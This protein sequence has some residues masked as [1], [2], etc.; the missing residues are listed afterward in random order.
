MK[1]VS[2]SESKAKCLG[3]LGQVRKTHTPVPVTRLGKPVAKVVPA[4]PGH[5]TGR[6]LGCMAGT[7]EI[8]GD[9]VVPTGGWG[10]CVPVISPS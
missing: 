3:I 8:L 2:T 9:I 6:H 5:G 1:E 10:D 7:S 4:S